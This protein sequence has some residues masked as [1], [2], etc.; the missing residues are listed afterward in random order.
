MTLLYVL[1]TSG[2][3]R[4]P[5]SRFDD[6]RE[7]R[8]NYCFTMRRR[9]SHATTASR[10]GYVISSRNREA[11]ERHCATKHVNIYNI[12]IYIYIY[13]YTMSTKQLTDCPP[14]LSPLNGAISKFTEPRLIVL[15]SRCVYASSKFFSFFT[16]PATMEIFCTQDTGLSSFCGRFGHARAYTDIFSRSFFP[17]RI[18]PT[19]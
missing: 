3:Q 12:Y 7:M 6:A 2:L 17:D 1:A 15:R 9:P 4:F 19:N 11:R 18:F 10:R 16:Y 13:I 8:N 5:V 14:S